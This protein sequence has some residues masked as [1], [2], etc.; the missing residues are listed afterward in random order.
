[1]KRIA[2]FIKNISNKYV[3]LWEAAY[4]FTI[5][6]KIIFPVLHYNLLQEYNVPL[7]L[8]KN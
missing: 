2:N 4:H 6:F 8:F 5:D 1:M 7:G 3:S